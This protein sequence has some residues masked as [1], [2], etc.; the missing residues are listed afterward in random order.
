[1]G[2]IYIL[3]EA[4]YIS[5]NQPI[6]R[7]GANKVLYNRT[8]HYPIGSKLLLEISYDDPDRALTEL[9]PELSKVSKP[10]P[11]IGPYYF[12]GN[13]RDMREIINKHVIK[14]DIVLP[15]PFSNHPLTDYSGFS[16][17]PLFGIS[18]QPKQTGWVET[19][20]K[21]IEKNK[22]EI[23]ALEIQAVKIREKI[24]RD[25]LQ[26]QKLEN[27]TNWFI[28]YYIA[29]TDKINSLIRPE[30]MSE[31]NY[32]SIP[33]STNEINTGDSIRD[34]GRNIFNTLFSRDKDFTVFIMSELLEKK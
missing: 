14:T 12:E 27:I 23:E 19:K 3:R 28:E 10:R 30:T 22:K 4:E 13:L 18:V 7:V 11:D 31:I 9:L 34:K 26:I 2:Y 21:Q 8:S 1:M 5:T 24:E 32:K 17:T 16:T 6:Y 25:K 33:L 15:N 29:N 20:E